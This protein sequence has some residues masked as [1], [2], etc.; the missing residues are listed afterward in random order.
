[1]KVCFLSHTMT[2]SMPVYGGNV[3]L[4]LK[5]VKSIKHNDSCNV[6]QFCIENH[7]GTHVDCPAHFFEHGS[8]VTDYPHD[9]WFFNNP[10]VLK[11][12]ADPGQIITKKD[13]PPTIN[14]KVD[15]LLFQSDWTYLRG[16]EVYTSHNPGLHPEIGMWLRNN[17]PAVRAVGMDWIS[18]SS[19][20]HRD[21]G[22]EAHRTF[23]NLDAEGHPIL[24]IEDMNLAFDLGNLKEVWVSPLLVEKVDSAPCTVIGIIDE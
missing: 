18:I 2:D 23:L 11:V 14:N 3:K 19:F 20:Q 8:K 21:I 12:H 1:M 16:K 15:F 5:S 4:N 7:W 9:F 13:L 24:I 17:F 6:W 22:R 10:Q